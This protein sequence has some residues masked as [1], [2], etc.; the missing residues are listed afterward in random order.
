MD[1]RTDSTTSPENKYVSLRRV[2]VCSCVT[3]TL[4]VIFVPVGIECSWR[5]M[6]FGIHVDCPDVV[7]DTGA[8]GDKVPVIVVILCNCMR[9]CAE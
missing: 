4:E 3:E 9:D 1:P 5:W 7:H 2:T 6:S 8:F